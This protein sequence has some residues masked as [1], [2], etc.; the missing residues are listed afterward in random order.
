VITG[1]VNSISQPNSLGSHH[2]FDLPV[3]VNR[4]DDKE[5]AWA[6]EKLEG[7]FPRNF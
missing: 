5:A 7:K 2:T 1:I 4:T 3:H 6:K